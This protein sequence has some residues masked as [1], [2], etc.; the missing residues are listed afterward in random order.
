MFRSFIFFR[1]FGSESQGSSFSKEDQIFSPASSQPAT[2]QRKLILAAYIRNL[3]PS[4][5]TQSSRPQEHDSTGSFLLSCSQ[6]AEVSKHSSTSRVSS[7]YRIH[8]TLWAASVGSR[9]TGERVTFGNS[10][11]LWVVT[12]TVFDWVHPSVLRQRRGTN[13]AETPNKAVFVNIFGIMPFTAQNKILDICF[14]LKGFKDH[15]GEISIP[16]GLWSPR[17][18][19]YGMC[20]CLLG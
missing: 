2:I 14:Q 11:L 9:K 17:T 7:H 4:C 10:E 12:P 8:F 20:L 13:P 5:I 3:V 15:V 19:S 16:G 6:G 1:L 18:F